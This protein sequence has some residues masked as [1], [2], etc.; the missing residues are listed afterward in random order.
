MQTLINILLKETVILKEEFL[1]KT[2]EWAVID[3]NRILERLK[4][5]EEQWC[6][7]L[8]IKAEQTSYGTL[9]FPKGFYN[10]RYARTYRNVFEKLMKMKNVPQADYVASQL[11]KAELHYESSIHKLAIRIKANV[12]LWSIVFK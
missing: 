4:W 3:Y 7:Y 8:G 12:F 1:A 5:T 10:T 9:G 11:K 2:Q 6:N